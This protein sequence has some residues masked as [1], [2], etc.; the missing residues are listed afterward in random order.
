VRR[1]AVV[2]KAIGAK[3]LAGKI[4][5]IHAH[6]GISIKSYATFEYPYCQSLEGLYYRQK[7][8]G[9]DFSVVFTYTTDLFFDLKTLIREGRMVPAAEPFSE[10]P[11]ALENQMLFMEVFRFCPEYRDRFLPFV[12]IDPERR[13]L[14]QLRALRELEQQYPI[15]G[16]KVVPVGCQSRISGLLEEGE[17][18]LEFAGERDLPL[19]I[20]V[21]VDPGETFSQASDTFRVIER[22]PGLRFCLAHCI[23]LNCEYLERAAA[24]PNVWVD[25][26][27]LKAQVQGAYENYAFMATPAQRFDW[28][29]S[30]H[31]QVM[32]ELVTRFPDTI[33]WGSD[34]PAYSYIVRR[35]QGP[36]NYLDFNFKG[37]YEEEKA[38]LDA[39]PPELAARAAS[40][41]TIA[42]LFG[43]G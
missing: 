27:A 12:I 2:G 13:I 33:V 11:Y 6:V 20:H 43:S 21:T 31:V 29:Y 10:A 19:L 25:T 22:Y 18:F 4:T 16:I 39:L 14:E 8:C 23:G 3:E 36:A 26:S 42:F 41:N 15:Y 30:N 38:A 40:T 1:G 9:V 34:S 17:A 37:T 7:L 5:D 35:L 24:A 28:D 32:R